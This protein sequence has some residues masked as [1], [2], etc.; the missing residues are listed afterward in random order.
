MNESPPASK[1]RW[2][3]RSSTDLAKLQ[4]VAE[5]A[6][7]ALEK[8]PGVADLA[9]VKSGEALQLL[10]R[11]KREMLGRFD[12]SM[13]DIQSFLATAL[14]GRVVG[15]LWEGDRVFSIVPGLAGGAR[16]HRAAAG[17]R[18][19]TPSGALIPSRRWPTSPSK[20]GFGVPAINRENGQRY[21]GIR[22]NVR[23]RDLGVLAWSRPASPSTRPSAP[24]R[25]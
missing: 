3:S 25:A 4:K 6:N 18:L 22:M 10:V 20:Y 2:R 15:D 11:P 5:K 13:Q 21:V 17:L 16:D 19:P 23:G 24:K 12:L 8:V 1:G 7:Q 9:I 14:G